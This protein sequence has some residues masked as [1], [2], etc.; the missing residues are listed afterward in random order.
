MHALEKDILCN[1][2]FRCDL[3]TQRCFGVTTSL[4]FTIQ[5]SAPICSLKKLTRV[6]ESL[7]ILLR[8]ER[9]HRKSPDVWWT[10]T[11][12]ILY[13]IRGY[14]A[15]TRTHTQYCRLGHVYTIAFKHIWK[16]RLWSLGSEK[17]FCCYKTSV[18]CLSHPL[19]HCDWTVEKK[20]TLME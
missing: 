6:A 4:K 3:R 16:L 12:K 14:H 13:P 15:R 9:F 2:I 17:S 18:W 20:V 10:Q 1:I 11:L 7:Q 8:F 19:L 5:L